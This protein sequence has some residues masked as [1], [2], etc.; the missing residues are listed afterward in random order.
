[1]ATR[2]DF[3]LAGVNADEFLV[4][5][6][7][8]L[9]QEAANFAFSGYAANA[10][11]REIGDIVVLTGANV[12]QAQTANGWV[13]I[14]YT[15]GIQPGR[16][17]QTTDLGADQAFPV[18]VVHDQWGGEI[19]VTA[20]QTS[21]DKIRRFWHGDPAGSAS[22]SSPASGI[23]QTYQDFGSS[24]SIAYQR[25]AIIH[26]T[27]K[28]ALYAFVYTKVYL[29]AS[30]SP[31]FQRTSTV[32]W[33]LTGRSLPDDRIVAPHGRMIRVFKTADNFLT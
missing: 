10:F 25:A 27:K 3:L 26:P 32:P 33:Q 8:F 1:M 2:E 11:P 29:S 13:H 30:Q 14:G 31:N 12:G 22:V 21:L 6:S 24:S 23:A 17:R 9:V 15:D 7:V 5:P 4:G 18:E 16:N 28:G 20:L 19:T